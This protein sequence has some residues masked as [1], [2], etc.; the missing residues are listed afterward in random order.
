MHTG[1]YVPRP[2]TYEQRFNNA[3]RLKKEE[4]VPFP[5]ILDGIGNE[6]R[7]LYHSL[8][9]PTFIID[10][11]IVAYKSSWTWSPDLKQALTEL[12]A[13]ERAKAKNEIVRMC[14]SEKLGGLTHKGKIS[15]QVH[16]RA[17][18]E[19]VKTFETLFQSERTK[20]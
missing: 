20:G 16:R 6:V 10:H 18:P 9:N 12:V 11:G 17:G 14:Y 3:R 8:T 4:K 5:I 15:A 2:T 7:R 19:A 1:E 13:Y